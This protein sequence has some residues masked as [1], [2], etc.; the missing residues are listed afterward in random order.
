MAVMDPQDHHF[1]QPRV[2]LV[3]FDAGGGHRAAAQA[4]IATAALEQRPWALQMTQLFEVLDPRQRFRAWTGMAP[5]AYYNTR[6][7]R[8]WTRGL[9]PELRLLQAGI[10]L[11]HPGLVRRLQAHWEGSQPDLVISVVPNFNR[12]LAESL[13]V[14]RPGVPFMTVMT[15]LA[16]L[17]PAFWIEPATHAHVVCGTAHAA[18]QARQAGCPP[19]RVH[20]VQG[21][22][23]RPEFHQARSDKDR[24]AHAT[25][26]HSLGLDP[27]TRTGVVMY[28]GQ[29]SAE[30]IDVAR[31]LPDVPLILLCGHNQ[32]LAARLRALPARAPR[33]VVGFTR[34]VRHWL[35]LGDFFIGKPG[36]GSLSEALQCGLPLL[37]TDNR[38]TLPQERFNTVW[39]REQGLGLGFAR[40]GDLP[41]A[42]ARLLSDEAGFRQRVGAMRNDAVGEVLRLAEQLLVQAPHPG[43]SSAP[44][45]ALPSAPP[46]I[47]CPSA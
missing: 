39:V 40:P 4:L 45:P 19:Q 27:Q 36:P 16:D 9:E 37:L 8:G 29:G 25:E 3:Y 21:M 5:E 20:R 17:P 26:R 41:E 24:D 47:A 2:E 14:A 22:I 7:S 46:Q 1:R 15:D 38:R 11:L 32:R 30:M 43:R 10:R 44:R 42:M 31:A 6:L 12:A 13:A 33:V 18:Q 23:L 35:E 28:G 34:E